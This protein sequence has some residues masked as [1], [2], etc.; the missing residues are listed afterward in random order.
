M[1]VKGQKACIIKVQELVCDVQSNHL[2]NQKTF[3]PEKT[4]HILELKL[5]SICN[6]LLLS[7]LDEIKYWRAQVLL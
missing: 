2:C 1:Q 4:P 6:L 3:F 7:N 5:A